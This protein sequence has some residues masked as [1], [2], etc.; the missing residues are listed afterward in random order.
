MN[1]QPHLICI[2][3]DSHAPHAMGLTGASVATPHLD[4]WARSAI[5]FPTCYSNSPV[6]GPSRFSF[7][8]G[9]FVH[10]CG[11]YDNAA[12]IPGD[13]PT[14][15]HLLTLAGYRTVFCGRMHLHGSDQYI[16]FEERPVHD[17][18][19]PI[20]SPPDCYRDDWRRED[21][22]L[23][24]PKPT[25]YPYAIR[26]TPMITYDDDVV[27]NSIIAQLDAVCGKNNYNFL[28]ADPGFDDD[29]GDI[30]ADEALETG[31]Q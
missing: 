14:M 16:G 25:P 13:Q 26:D 29:S 4:A 7:L 2:M 6:C 8:T 12:T 3:S 5:Y 31:D 17:W 1:K 28:L 20:D 10:Q 11:A 18:I 30:I 24:V 27:A 22:P 9:R 19:N 15:G 21:H 23:K